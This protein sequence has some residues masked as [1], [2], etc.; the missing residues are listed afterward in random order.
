MKMYFHVA[1]NYTMIEHYLFRLWVM[2]LVLTKVNKV[3]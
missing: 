1:L 3:D 2:N